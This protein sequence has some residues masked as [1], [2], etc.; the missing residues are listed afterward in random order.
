M[1]WYSRLQG[2]KKNNQTS[3]DI[4]TGMATWALT[5]PDSSTTGA[6]ALYNAIP[7]VNEVGCTVIYEGEGP[8]RAE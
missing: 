6:A 4:A 8:L 3:P 7:D 5:D 2:K 1:P